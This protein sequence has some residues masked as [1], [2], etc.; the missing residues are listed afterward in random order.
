MKVSFLILLLSLSLLLVCVRS[1]VQQENDIAMNQE[2]Q[3]QGHQEQQEQQP[4]RFLRDA[5]NMSL[6]FFK[7]LFYT[8]LSESVEPI[9]V[10]VQGWESST[11]WGWN[12]SIFE[13]MN[14]SKPFP[15]I[16]C[17]DATGTSQ[18]RKRQV[19]SDAV[20]IDDPNDPTIDLNEY[21]VTITNK[22][23]ITC[24]FASINGTKA[25]QLNDFIVQPVTIF[26]KINGGTVS[27]TAETTNN[28]E[29]QYA[30]WFAPGLFDRNWTAWSLNILDDI[31]TV[32]EPLLELD[33]VVG[34]YQQN[35]TDLNRYLTE[36]DPNL[37]DDLLRNSTRVESIITNDQTNSSDYVIVTFQQA[38][39]NE[40]S[41]PLSVAGETCFVLWVLALAW[42][43]EVGYIE[44]RLPT[45][46]FNVIEQWIGQS[47]I[48]E[49]RP[50]FDND[51]TGLDQFIAVSDTGLDLQNCYFRDDSIMN[52]GRVRFFLF[53]VFCVLLFLVFL[54]VG[55]CG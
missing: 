29:L 11:E 30:V 41:N 17:D 16:L 20:G 8:A 39:L 34:A 35:L 50:F 53:C 6:E 4:Q 1:T 26:M 19:A 24:Y 22:D 54:L 47:S 52:F 33:F 48:E 44:R 7:T 55:V 51:I 28:D 2:Q 3:Q 27:F 21:F 10:Q 49:Y 18:E 45:N 13:E 23:N 31:L 12:R 32:L 25:E 36:T 37:C 42:A 38:L 43:P 5:K 9:D 40:S 14:K 46:T 15:F